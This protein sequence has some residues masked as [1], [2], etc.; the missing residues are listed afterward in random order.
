M[1]EYRQG[2]TRGLGLVAAENCFNRTAK[3]LESAGITWEAPATLNGAPW[4]EHHGPTAKGL[5][6]ARLLPVSVKNRPVQVA[7]GVAGKIQRWLPSPQG[8]GVPE[9]LDD[10]G[11]DAVCP[12]S[13]L[14][15]P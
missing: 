9:F 10:A 15:C 12:A 2:P 14:A 11:H 3:L 5:L 8:T 4:N 6:A 13:H 7:T 1:E